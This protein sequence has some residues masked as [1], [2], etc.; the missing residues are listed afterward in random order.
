M[1]LIIDIIG[2]VV[3][4]GMEAYQASQVNEAQ[5]LV[6]LDAAFASSRVRIKQALEVLNDARNAA[7]AKIAAG[8]QPKGK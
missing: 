1:N 3:K 4:V 8:F 2:G 5:A 6:M 7:D